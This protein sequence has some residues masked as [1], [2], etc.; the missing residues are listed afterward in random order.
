MEEIISRGSSSYSHGAFDNLLFM[1]LL[2]TPKYYYWRNHISEFSKCKENSFIIDEESVTPGTVSLWQGTTQ[3]RVGEGR[4]LIFNIARLVSMKI[5]W[6]GESIIYEI[7]NTTL[8]TKRC[9]F[10]LAFSYSKFLF[11]QNDFWTWKMFGHIGSTILRV[12]IDSQ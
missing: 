9:Y 5:V 7:C 12:Q 11:D 4:A 2:E 3:L 1:C 6:V 10:F 8:N